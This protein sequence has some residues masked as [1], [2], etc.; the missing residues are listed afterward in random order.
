M[1]ERRCWFEPR[2]AHRV[3]AP[4]FSAAEHSAPPST[5]DPMDLVDPELRPVLQTWL[6]QSPPL[7]WSEK[8]LADIRRKSA[9]QARPPLGPAGLSGTNDS[10]RGGRAGRARGCDRHGAEGCAAARGTAH[11]RRR[12]HGRQCRGRH[13]HAAAAFRRTRLC[14]RLGRLSARAGNP[15]SRFA[16][17]Q[18]RGAALAARERRGAGRRPSAYCAA[19][20]KRRRRPCRRIGSRSARSRRSAGR[21]ASDAIPHAGRSDGQQ[22]R[23]A[24]VPG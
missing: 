3:V 4:E 15:V 20:R 9:S 5:I 2:S 1:P 13:C 18:L 22:P 7:V 24:T 8:I 23:R 10:W 16:R 11:S 19:G 12:L 6:K 21:H 17:G 14:G